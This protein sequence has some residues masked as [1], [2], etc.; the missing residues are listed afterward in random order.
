[1]TVPPEA[2]LTAVLIRE[3]GIPVLRTGQPLSGGLVDE[4]MEA[5]RAERAQSIL[6]RS[7]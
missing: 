3:H 2:T 4:V 6:S 7:N 1:M 5:V